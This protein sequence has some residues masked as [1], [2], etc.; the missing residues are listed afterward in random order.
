MK[1]KKA[2]TIII[3]IVCFVVLIMICLVVAFFVQFN[4]RYLDS[5]VGTLEMN[6][7]FLNGGKSVSRVIDCDVTQKNGIMVS[8]VY[9]NE[10]VGLQTQYRFRFMRTSLLEQDPLF[11]GCNFKLTDADGKVLENG[12]SIFTVKIMGITCREIVITFDYDEIETFAPNLF[13]EVS[14]KNADDEPYAECK[15][16]IPVEKIATSNS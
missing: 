13:F 8:K 11:S 7:F 2:T 6:E 12:F 4:G 15:F 10:L 9:Q 14:L 16:T 3:K 1:E 5:P